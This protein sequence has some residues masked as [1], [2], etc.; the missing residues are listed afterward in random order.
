MT[1]DEDAP[2]LAYATFRDL[3]PPSGDWPQAPPSG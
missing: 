3:P 2:K 1:F